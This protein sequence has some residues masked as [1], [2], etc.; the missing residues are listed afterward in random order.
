[1]RVVLTGFNSFH[2]VDHNPSQ[3]V[4]EHFARHSDPAAVAEVLPTEYAA[5]GRRVRA[6]VREHSPDLV[7]SLGVAQVRPTV[8]LERVALNLD[9]SDTPD[10]AGV[11]ARGRLI[12]DGAPLAYFATLP[13][14]AML[15][16]LWAAKVP[17]L[18]TNHAGTFVCNHVFYCASHEIDRAGLAARCGFLHLPALATPERPIG[19]PLERMIEAVECCLRAA[20][21]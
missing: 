4:V 14:D 19:L 11:V 1:M 10:N 7:L 2:G 18:I 5:A 20:G 13:I 12:H 15:A 21:A 9:D 6:L 17:A 16:A 3:L 8:C